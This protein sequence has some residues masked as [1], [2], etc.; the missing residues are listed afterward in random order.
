M[1]KNIISLISVLSFIPSVTFAMNDTFKDLVTNVVMNGVLVP[2]VPIL[3]SLTIIVFIFG[4]LK[5]MK[6]SDSKERGEGKM[7]MLWGI[8]G[9]FVMVSVWGLVNILQNSFDLNNQST[10]VPDIDLNNL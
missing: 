5:F 7:Y 8:I 3:I 6:S 1:K 2:I 4:I 9:I 10:I